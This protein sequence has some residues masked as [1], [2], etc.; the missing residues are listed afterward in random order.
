MTLLASLATLVAAAATAGGSAPQAPV[1]GVQLAAADVS[2]R[3]IQPAIV[4]QA[5]GVEHD[6][7]GPQP[8]IRRSGRT[9]LVE[10]Q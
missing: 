2:A 8:R 7:D 10:Y 1:R 3:I 4:R 6:E 5:S 9:I